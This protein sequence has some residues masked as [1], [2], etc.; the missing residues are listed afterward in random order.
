MLENRIKQRLLQGEASCLTADFTTRDLAEAI[1]QG[2]PLALEEYER[3]CGYL[4]V[5]IV[6]LINQFNPSTIVIGDQ[7]V[8]LAPELLL[9]LVREQVRERLRPAIWEG[10]NIEVNRSEYNPIVMGAAALAAQTI[11]EDPFSY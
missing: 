1:R 4:V 9:R 11:L 8:D 6:N 2:D 10:L 3:N 7:L 5:G